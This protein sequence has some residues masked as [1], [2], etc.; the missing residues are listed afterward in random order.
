[1]TKQYLLLIDDDPDEYE[2][3]LHALGKIPD[4]FEC[5]HA[6]DAEAALKKLAV[7]QPDYILMDVNMPAVNG[8]ECT[9]RIRKN[10][11]FDST[12]IFIYTTGYDQALHQESIGAGADGCVR[13][14]ARQDA[15]VAMLTNLHLNGRI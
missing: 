12:R 4:V 15:L 5:D 2:F 7:R 3:F 11:A 6:P 10:K 14:P 8:I 1:M 9:R 13:K